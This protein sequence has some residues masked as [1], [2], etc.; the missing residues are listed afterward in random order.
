M[1]A[2]D[3]SYAEDE[4]RLFDHRTDLTDKIFAL[5]DLDAPT[6]WMRTKDIKAFSGRRRPFAGGSRRA[7]RR[8]KTFTVIVLFSLLP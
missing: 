2:L 5:V 7:V 3:C 8:S 4:W 1:R 6:K